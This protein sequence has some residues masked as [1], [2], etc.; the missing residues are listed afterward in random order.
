MERILSAY[1]WEYVIESTVS[2]P[3]SDA[4]YE[5]GKNLLT[6]GP[7]DDLATLLGQESGSRRT[8]EFR[9]RP[10]NEEPA[11]TPDQGDVRQV[12]AVCPRSEKVPRPPKF[13]GI[14]PF[15]FAESSGR[16]RIAPAANS[17][18]QGFM[19]GKTAGA[20]LVRDKCPGSHQ[21]VRNGGKRHIDTVVNGIGTVQ[22]IA[23]DILAVRP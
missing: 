11:I 2:E 16:R 19:K 23:T 8:G 22:E 15:V 4:G 7:A 10:F 5:L 3:S 12:G 9:R 6:L 21:P 1:P 17:M 14:Q 13:A 20:F 18:A